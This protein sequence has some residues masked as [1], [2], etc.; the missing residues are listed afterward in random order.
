MSGDRDSARLQPDEVVS[1]TDYPNR[2]RLVTAGISGSLA[3]LV[4]GIGFALVT[5]E[6]TA[7]VLAT[8][9]F[10]L[11]GTAVSLF[12]SVKNTRLRFGIDWVEGPVE[13][14]IGDMLLR[15]RNIAAMEVV[16]EDKIRLSRDDGETMLVDLDHYDFMEQQMIRMRL[17]SLAGG[18]TSTPPESLVRDS[19]HRGPRRRSR[20]RD[21]P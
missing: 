14:G 1:A 6:G 2:M 11:A 12:G 15:R 10:V 3:G 9:A 7:S 8:A 4:V 20:D 17:T 18:T 19:R 5:G 13:G 21:R 16:G